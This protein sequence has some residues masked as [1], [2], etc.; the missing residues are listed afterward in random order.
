MSLPP[1]S[2]G[3]VDSNGQVQPGFPPPG[4]WQASDT[5]WYPPERHPM[6]QPQAVRAPVPPPNYHDDHRISY[7]QQPRPGNRRWVVPL[8][9]IGIFGLFFGG[10]IALIAGSSS[11]DPIATETAE[12]VTTVEAEP[13]VDTTVA[14]APTDDDVD[15]TIEPAL[16]D[17]EDEVELSEDEVELSE[18]DEQAIA[19]LAFQF[20]VAEVLPD[21]SRMSDEAVQAFGA[22]M[23]EASSGVDT[24]DAFALVMLLAWES[25]EPETQAT[26]NNDMEAYALAVGAAVG[27]FCPEELERLGL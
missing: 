24:A 11:D 23:C 3:W 6:A 25:A 20:T 12:P 17:D 9:L 4:W 15:T 27:A 7:Q 22:A 5:R 1:Q 14:P 21:A 8:V 18:D 10:C 19:V 2:N 13:A 16:A 26:F